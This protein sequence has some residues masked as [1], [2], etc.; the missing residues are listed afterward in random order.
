[1][2]L[3]A[4]FP[5]HGGKGRVAELIWKRLGHIDGYYEPFFGSGAVL[6][7]APR[8]A[9]REVICDLSPHIANFWRAM[10]DNP[11]AVAEAADYPTIHH[12]LIARHRYLDEWGIENGERLLDDPHFYNAEVAGWW[13]WGMSNWIGGR[14]CEGW[15]VDGN[16]KDN[17]PYMNTGGQGVQIQSTN[18][19]EKIPH[20][21]NDGTSQGIQMGRENVPHDKRPTLR[22]VPG[23]FGVQV[24]VQGQ[25]P[26]MASAPSGFGVQSQC[27]DGGGILT[28]ARLLPWFNALA[29]RLARVI[30]L[31]RDWKSA[32]TDTVTM[33]RVKAT[34]G[35]ML[36]PPYLNG[37]RSALYGTDLGDSRD[38]AAKA[39]YDWAVERGNDKR[40]RIVYCCHEG[41][42][43]LPDGWT[44]HTS[45]FGGIRRQDRIADRRDILM[46][47][48]HCVSDQ[49]TDL[50]A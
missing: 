21:K 38:D 11:A 12:D 22:D 37:D 29:E 28:G 43:P 4:P 16:L 23:G 19:P 50:F 35:V 46:F 7:S 5:Y 24:Q 1:M 34:C 44:S 45:S 17:I 32:L 8:I 25:I 2:K 20:M 3:K 48:P 49:Q 31:R 18:L 40:F 10:R 15:A 41:D 30:V 47:S 39:S 14:F 9:K 27:D 13:A 36:D 33:R 6:L 26:K 42:F